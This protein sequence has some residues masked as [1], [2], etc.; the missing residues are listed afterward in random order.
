MHRPGARVFLA[1]ALIALAACSA[2]GAA[3]ASADGAAAPAVV[4]ARAAIAIT[5]VPAAVE[6]RSAVQA[7]LPVPAVAPALVAPAAADLIIRWEVSGEANYRRRL[8]RPIWPGGASGITWGIGYD[9]GHNT[10]RDIR[11]AWAG[12]AAADRLAGAAGIAGV[13]ARAALPD[14]ADI[15][16][17]WPMARGVFAERS[18][19]AYRTSAR[20]AFGAPGFDAL[21]PGAQGA[22]VSLVYNRGASMAGD[23]NTEKRAIRDRCLPAADVGCV[24]AQLRAMCRLW[25]GTPNGAGLC[26]RRED[27]ARLAEGAT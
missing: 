15:T 25:V 24:G 16:V 6:M 18:L 1:V 21:P 8:E 9:G 10:A 4:S 7:L 26:R 17:P 27:E 13:P 23:R 19:P 3:P 2:R 11:A 5:A 20:R 14:Y 12:H 22:L